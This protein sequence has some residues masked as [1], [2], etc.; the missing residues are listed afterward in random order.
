MH[1]VACE[2]FWLETFA[3]GCRRSPAELRLTLD[4]E[5]RQ[6][7]GFWP[8]P[9]REEIGWYYALHDRV[10][11]RAFERLRDDAAD[12]R[13]ARKDFEVSLGWVVAHVAQHEAYHGGQAVLLQDL[14]R[15]RP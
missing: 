5:T 14:W 8:A 4:Q 2:S 1:I 13:I 7:G 10:R 11:S 9:P 12:R 3:R 6:Y 15:H